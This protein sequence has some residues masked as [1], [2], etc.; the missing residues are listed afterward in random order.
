MTCCMNYRNVELHEFVCTYNEM[1][2]TET[3]T[4]LTSLVLRV[5]DGK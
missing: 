2:Y 5:S 3:E 1:P 4:A